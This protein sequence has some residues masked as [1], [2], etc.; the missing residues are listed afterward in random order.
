M[1]FF[2]ID[3]PINYP[4][5]KLALIQRIQLEILHAVV[6][7]R[8]LIIMCD[9]NALLNSGER[10]KLEGI[11]KKLIELGYSICQIESFSHVELHK[12]E[13]LHI[14]EQGKSVGC[15]SRPEMN[16][17]EIMYLINRNDFSEDYN[18][19]FK[20][21]RKCLFRESKEPILEIPQKYYGQPNCSIKVFKGEIIEVCCKK[22][23]DY[24]R[25]LNEFYN[26]RQSD[27]R[28]IFKGREL[29]NKEKKVAVSNFKI[30]LV[31]LGKINNSLFEKI[32]IIENLCFPLCY[33]V[34]GFF[35]KKKYLRIAEE[36]IATIMPELDWHM[37]VR[38]LSQEQ[39]LRL[40]LCKWILCKPELLVMFVPSIMVK[41][42][43]D[44]ILDRII[45]EF[46]KYGIPVVI[47]SEKYHFQTEIIEKRYIKCERDTVSIDDE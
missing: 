18:K 1:R 14:I 16:Y 17:S 46:S 39:I 28:I 15:L 9:V 40:N 12:L 38:S 11:Y 26:K 10:N 19:L 23:R 30:G 29:N 35:R 33:K 8:K 6:N 37:K 31:D 5:T 22:E 4:V 47:I 41:E 45:V 25:L 36:Y 34:P 44:I 21:K 43:A 3:I 7:K 13:Y 32:S 42:E 27:E 2:D 20:H 24:L